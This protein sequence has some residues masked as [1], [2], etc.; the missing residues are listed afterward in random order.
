[1]V[2]DT[3]REIIPYIVPIRDMAYGAGVFFHLHECIPEKKD[4]NILRQKRNHGS[5]E[6]VCSR[7]FTLPKTNS[8]PL[9]KGLHTLK[10][11]GSSPK[12]LF[13]RGYVR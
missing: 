1:M 7:V 2:I 11:K 4:N 12:P 8:S 3:C 6:R 5:F 9:K 13:F 10:W